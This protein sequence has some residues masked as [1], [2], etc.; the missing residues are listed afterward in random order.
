[1]ADTV[2][3]DG[4]VGGV[5]RAIGV[6][7]AGDALRLE[8]NAA[9]VPLVVHVF[10][11]RRIQPVVDAADLAVTPSPIEDEAHV[12]SD[13]GGDADANADMPRSK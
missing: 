6:V 4:V 5:D 1:M 13:A 9:V 11:F 8:V 3:P 10:E 2:S 7:V 12:D